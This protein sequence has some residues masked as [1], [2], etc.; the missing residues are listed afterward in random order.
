MSYKPKVLTQAEGGTGLTA[1]SAAYQVPY[2]TGWNYPGTSQFAVIEHWDDFIGSTSTAATLCSFTWRAISSG[3]S[4]QVG[5]GTGDHPGILECKSNSGTTDT[6]AFLSSPAMLLF[7]GGVMTLEGVV[8]LPVLSDNT[9]TYT[10]RFGYGDQGSAG[11]AI[12]DGAWFQ[13]TNGVNSGNWTINTSSNSSPT[14]ANTSTAVTTSWVRLKI[15]SN[16]AGTEIHFYVNG[17]EVANSPITNTIP[18][19][20][21]RNF[22]IMVD[23]AKTAGATPTVFDTD[24]IYFRKVLTTPR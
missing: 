10:A 18:T 21:G 9:N 19:G 4:V 11:G 5:V 6:A 14:A 17:T 7:G 1:Q 3:G 13:Y 23:F 22:G 12:V 16:A 8:N 15:E 2:S 24:L 20:A